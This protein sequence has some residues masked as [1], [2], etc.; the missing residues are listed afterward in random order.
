M[1]PLSPRPLVLVGQDI[2]SHIP[3][4]NPGE[5]K[6]AAFAAIL[7]VVEHKFNHAKTVNKAKTSPKFRPSV[8]EQKP[9]PKI[10]T[11]LEA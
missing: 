11:Q 1:G 7:F 9:E 3:P 4:L 8:D 2:Q 6:D 5:R 10:G